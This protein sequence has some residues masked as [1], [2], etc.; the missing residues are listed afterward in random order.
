MSIEKKAKKKLSNLIN[1]YNNLTYIFDT[2]TEENSIDNE[3]KWKDLKKQYKKAKKLYTEYREFLYKKD[4]D[5]DDFDV[6]SEIAFKLDGIE[7]HLNNNKPFSYLLKKGA[8]TLL[9][10]ILNPIPNI[11][12]T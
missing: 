5:F 6:L 4:T 10:N 8:Y 3:Y 9:K 11:Y 1:E 2:I 7:I 12:G